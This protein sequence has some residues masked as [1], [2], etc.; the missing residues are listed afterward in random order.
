MPR[1]IRRRL[2]PPSMVLLVSE[3]CVARNLESHIVVGILSAAF[4][5]SESRR[6][7]ECME[8]IQQAGIVRRRLWIARSTACCF[9]YGVM[10]VFRVLEFLKVKVK[11]VQVWIRD[12]ICM[13][14]RFSRTNYLGQ[15]NKGS[16]NKVKG[17]FPWRRLVHGWIAG[18]RL[19][20]N[21][22]GSVVYFMVTTA[23][24]VTTYALNV[25]TTAL[26]IL[27]C[28]SQL[29]MIFPKSRPNN[30]ID[31]GIYSP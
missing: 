23:G 1:L 5:F 26:N 12:L 4:Y 29:D 13:A 25:S 9:Q 18:M 24:I 20:F 17:S 10:M 8:Q 31:V 28:V 19:G 6:V 21:V 30:M 16:H 22:A 11:L 15:R 27:T 3:V 14:T 2:A 7:V